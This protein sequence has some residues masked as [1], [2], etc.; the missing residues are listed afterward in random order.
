MAGRSSCV[1]PPSPPSD[2]ARELFRW[3]GGT[4]RGAREHSSVPS[5]PR[6]TADMRDLREMCIQYGVVAPEP[7]VA[8]A[9][10]F[11]HSRRPLNGPF[12]EKSIGHQGPVEPVTPASSPTAG[13]R[14]HLPNLPGIAL[15]AGVALFA[16]A[17]AAGMK[18]AL[19]WGPPAMV[20]AVVLG[21]A[22]ASVGTRQ[23]F[24]S[25]LTWC[26]KSL[27]RYAIALLG[28]RIV[29][30]DIVGLGA[31]LVVV[32]VVSMALT[33]VSAVALSRAFGL[34]DGYGAL[35]GAATA[36]CGASATLAT[37]T[38]VPAYPN[39]SA[40]VAFT[41]IM[42]NA[43]STLVMLAYPYLAKVMG[44]DA[45]TTGILLG[46]SI[47]DMAQVV[48]A[49]YAVSEPVGNTA[50]IVKL[51]RVGLLLPV[52]LLIGL[53]F[54]RAAA[55]APGTSAAKA[56]FPTFALVFLILAFVNTALLAVPALAEIYT[57]IRRML[58]LATD[59]AMLV[60]I[61]ALGLMTSLGSVRALGL[62]HVMVFFGA[63]LVIL[64]L[65][66]AGLAVTGRV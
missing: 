56:P 26:V 58:M 43:V 20:S 15:A 5:P 47:H 8:A 45:T 23:P 50:V 41:V 10:S 60:A 46:A 22:L 19:S 63:T 53:W 1:T 4:V 38:V 25:G 57:P 42:A 17:L 62:R 29:L 51:M 48:G 64:A 36:V 65:V 11:P 55:A 59:A 61:A 54:A 27:L 40:D 30:S 37:A 2:G 3:V 31:D 9:G 39:K 14:R 12:S 18:S 16:Y 24:P 66:L 21:I 34:G 44:L 7:G 13:L 52:V 6:I 32:V 33:I 49:G 28:L 35:S